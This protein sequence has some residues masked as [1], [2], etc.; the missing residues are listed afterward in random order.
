MPN[1]RV[2]VLAIVR[3]PGTGALLVDEARDPVKH[4]VFHRPSGGGVEFGETAV[5]ALVREF[6]EEFDL[7][8]EVGARLGVVE[9]IFTFAGEPGHEIL[10]LH[11][12][13]LADPAAYAIERFECL[14]HP[15]QY[16]VW[17]DPAL[18]H[19]EV[20]LYPDGLAELLADG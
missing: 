10:F 15:D 8:I 9:N 20:P 17:R 18:T 4:E 6:R 19:A 14:D 7:A 1:P 13:R 11:A 12:A 2:S 3:H 5:T 16:A